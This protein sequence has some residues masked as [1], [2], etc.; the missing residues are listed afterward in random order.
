MTQRVPTSEEEPGEQAPAEWS[1]LHLPV[2]GRSCR[3]SEDRAGLGGAWVDVEASVGLTI[4]DDYDA[5]YSMLDQQEE[6]LLLA[7]IE[8]L[9]MQASLGTLIYESRAPADARIDVKQMSLDKR[10]LELRLGPRQ[11]RGLAKILTRIY[12]TE[13]KG[14]DRML[15]MLHVNAK[16]TANEKR[17]EQNNHI[18]NAGRRLDAHGW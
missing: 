17:A 18:T 11:T 13:P 3:L 9:L 12:F 4:D 15:L 5:L 7:E 1:G 8:D 10:I 14:H 6:A 2:A 16:N